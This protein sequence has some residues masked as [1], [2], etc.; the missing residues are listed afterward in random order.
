MKQKILTIV[1]VAFLLMVNKSNAQ[2]PSWIGTTPPPILH[3]NPNTT[4]VGIGTTS[5]SV[6]LD[7]ESGSTKDGI[8]INMIDVGDPRISFQIQN[9]SKFTMGVD[10]S[11]VDK[12][13]IGVAAVDNKTRVTID[14][15]GN[16]GISTTTPDGLLHLDNGTSDTDLII[17]KD[18]GT[19]ADIIFHNAGIAKAHIAFDA[20]LDILIEN[21]AQDEDIIFKINDGG[22]DTEIMR[23]D[24]SA[25]K[26]GIGTTGP[27]TKLHLNESGASDV[28]FRLTPANGANDALLQM[29]GQG[30]DITLEGFVIRYDNDVGDIYFDQVFTGSTDAFHFRTETGGTPR[31]VVTIQR[32]GNVGIGTTSPSS[33]LEVNGEVEIVTLQTDL[34]GDDVAVLWDAPGG[35]SGTGKLTKVSSSIRY[36]QNVQNLS[37][38]KDSVLKL[39]PVQFQWKNSTSGKYDVGLIAEEVEQIMPN[40]VYYMHPRDTIIIDSNNVVVYDTT[41]TELEGVHYRKLPVYL[42][43]IVQEQEQRIAQLDSL[44]NL[45]C[46]GKQKSS[47]NNSGSNEELIRVVHFRWN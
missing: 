38:Y 11:D 16:V 15:S 2:L 6:L 14:S 47:Y 45:C 36:K 46:T 29:T 31:E 35:A 20:N 42:L 5:P 23:I 10:D 37:M 9:A 13:K 17:E 24:G 1:T 40:L 19:S 4:K 12:F 30:N 34:G 21:D 18:D 3:T 7:I 43:A 32:I 25:S 41:K 44:I 26:V 39:R 8:D 22:V 27:S 33:K 28:I